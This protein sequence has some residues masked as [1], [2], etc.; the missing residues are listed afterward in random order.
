MFDIIATFS[1][2]DYSGKMKSDSGR[3]NYINRLMG[4]IGHE[5]DPDISAT[6]TIRG[7]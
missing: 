3:I 6:G 2:I 7:E 5:P 4:V 1:F